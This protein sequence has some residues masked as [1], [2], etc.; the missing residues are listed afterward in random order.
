M[1]DDTCAV[2]ETSETA[3]G[4]TNGR[5]SS[6]SSA[7]NNIYKISCRRGRRRK[8]SSLVLYGRG[9]KKPPPSRIKR[10]NNVSKGVYD[11]RL[12][13]FARVYIN[14]NVR[15]PRP[16][17]R[18][19]NGS[20]LGPS[21]RSVPTNVRSPRTIKTRHLSLPLC[22]RFFFFFSCARVILFCCVCARDVYKTLSIKTARFEGRARTFVLSAFVAAEYFWHLSRPSANCYFFFLIRGKKTKLLLLCL[23][24]FNL[25]YY[26]YRNRSTVRCRREQHKCRLSFFTERDGGGKKNGISM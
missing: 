16:G 5:Q 8:T 7:S 21:E 23:Y 18:K 25:N 2:R 1:L 19:R 15:T 24:Y 20:H 9:V 11:E 6:S 4:Q 10:D 14:V 26:I 17:N 13:T 3:L 22:G 12:V